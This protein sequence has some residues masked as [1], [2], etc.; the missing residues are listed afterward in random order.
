M[1]KVKIYDISGRLLVE[2][3]NIDSNLLTINDIK[4]IADQVL[5]VSILT[6]E[7]RIINK[8]VF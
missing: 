3:T 8:K 7:N 5:L 2:K 4:G 6:N 1:N